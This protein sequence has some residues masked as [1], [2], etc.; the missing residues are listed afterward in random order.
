MSGKM[1]ETD[2]AAPATRYLQGL[3]F[4]VF[5]E[6]APWGGGGRRADVVG[7]RKSE[8]G[9]PLVYIIELKV[10]L[11]LAVMDQAIE[12]IGAAHWISVGVPTGRHGGPLISHALNHFGIGHLALSVNEYDADHGMD[13]RVV[14]PPRFLRAA[15][16]ARVV[17]GCVPETAAG[18][19]V[20]AAGSAGGG[21]YTPFN[22]TVRQLK[23]FILDEERR[24]GAP[25]L[26][27]TA[28]SSIT[29]HYVRDSSATATLAQWI[30]NGHIAGLTTEVINGKLHAR[31]LP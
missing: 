20:L 31:A 23:R 12:W 2:L 30:R 21:Y 1:S 18:A 28:V 27:K 5:H 17:K 13:A 6:V 11:G 7:L 4:E 3:G 8:R 26:F 16:C 25:V 14:V 24:T 10:S 22:N 19:A 29:H 15:R 9:A